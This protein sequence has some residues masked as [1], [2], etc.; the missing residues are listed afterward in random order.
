MS[1]ALPAC[2]G[3]PRRLAAVLCLA[4]ATTAA[5]GQSLDERL[6]DDLFLRGLIE[7]ELPEVLEH[8]IRT[9]P[10][11]DP[12]QAARY[13]IA[14]QRLRLR[15][16]SGEPEKRLA[17]IERI[18]SVRGELIEEEKAHPQRAIW[19]TDQA[20]DLF[21]ELLP[22]EA[23]DLT[24][25]FGLPTEVQRR[26]AARVARQMNELT[27]LAEVEI[28]RA[29]RRIEEADGYR[30]DESLQMQRRRLA[31]DERE[32]RIPFL[33][34]I[35][36]FLHA[37]LDLRSPSE[38]R[39][40]C[41]IAARQLEPLDGEL[42][43]GSLLSRE[44]LY[45]GLALARL[46]RYEEAEA[47]FRQ[48]ATDES[49]A[50][51]DIFAA[52]MGGVVNRADNRGLDAALTALDSIEPKYTGAEGL[53]YRVLIADQRFLLRR[54]QALRES[55]DA[56]SDA[57]S[58]AFAAYL[59]LLND[60]ESAGPETMRA[61][62]FARLAQAADEQTPVA[63]LPAIVA[64]ARADRL[65]RHEERPEKAIELLE[66]VLGR[67]DLA[68]SEQ[69]AALFAL[70]RALYEAGRPIEASQC[71]VR[72]ARE[73]PIEG[74]APRAVELAAGIA[75]DLHREF[76]ADGEVRQ[77]LHEAL[78]VL[79]EQFPDLPDIDHWRYVAGRLAMSEGDFPAA[80]AM[81]RRLAP[82]AERW[83]DAQFMQVNALLAAVK[84]QPDGPQ[85]RRD[86]EE[87]IAVGERA[88]RA[89][90]QALDDV[91]ASRRGDLLYY[92]AFLRVFRAEALRETDREEAALEAL[93]G[94][95]REAG[96]DNAILAAALRVRIDAHQALGRRE[97][98]RGEI[99]R[100]L[101]A[102]PN[103]AGGVIDSMLSSMLAEVQSLLEV[104]AD[105][106]ARNQAQRE[107][108][109]LA[110]LLERWIAGADLEEGD[111]RPLL[112]RAAD[113]YRLAGL[114]DD[115]LRLYD[116][117]LRRYPDA[118]ELLFGR[119]ECLFGLEDEREAE[120][121]GLYKRI[122]AAGPDAGHHYYWQSQLRMLQILDRVQQNVQRIAP[123]ISRLRLQ[124]PELGGDRYRRKFQRL[125]RKYAGES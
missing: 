42:L 35:A 28:Q 46:G 63:E 115:A 12:V 118:V 86:A 97:D 51:R 49:T 94:I 56:R 112:R 121:M 6:D 60:R 54:A 91:S 72:M 108:A 102:A 67:D 77:V 123:R 96:L 58:D 92:L 16:L 81:F 90:R 117:L 14:G 110:R 87:L 69:A 43:E 80:V 21:F 93:S 29:I 103:E 119:A 57:M 33:R 45:R 66:S 7:L 64:V 68:P 15:G 74:E 88:E 78:A 101:E 124:D 34:G 17:A 104:G 24:A 75:A 109:P 22:T 83:P 52:R 125:E 82:T 98:A 31:R 41:E 105:E 44:R 37:E 8:Y 114:F 106:A 71:F 122:V 79:L 30:E 19:L 55:G 111:R 36:A 50:A 62:V 18:L 73:H 39:E 9:H 26:R 5:T 11:A 70:G 59:D 48:V 53:F 99:E 113:V 89:L 23:T 76:P 85:R 95:E 13:T 10:P 2:S 47:L 116:R 20:A 32:R 107:L 120:A 3:G 38:K 84:A 27:T 4:L 40:F 1:I 65:L 100:L 25:L 61:I